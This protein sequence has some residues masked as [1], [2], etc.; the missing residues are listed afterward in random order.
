MGTTITSMPDNTCEIEIF[1]AQELV[2]CVESRKLIVRDIT[3]LSDI[4]NALQTDSQGMFL[5]A[6]LQIE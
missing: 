5:W 4:R 3:L 2:R 1:V 6:V